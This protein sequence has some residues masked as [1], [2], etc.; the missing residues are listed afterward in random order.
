MPPLALASRRFV[1]P[2]G[3]VG[4]A[5]RDDVRLYSAATKAGWTADELRKI[6]FDEPDKQRRVARRRQRGTANASG[7]VQ[8][9]SA[10]IAVPQHDRAGSYS[11]WKQG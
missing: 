9:R 5:E 8:Q 1:E 4:A 3:A 2:A 7:E 6:G 10:T 11:A